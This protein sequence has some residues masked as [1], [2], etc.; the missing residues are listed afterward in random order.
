MLTSTRRSA[1]VSGLLIG[2]GAM[3]VCALLAATASAG[4][5]ITPG[6]VS[7]KAAPA[8]MVL[9]GR[10]KTNVKTS[11]NGVKHVNVDLRS[12]RRRYDWRD[13]RDWHR[14]NRRRRTVRSPRK[15]APA[16]AKPTKPVALKERRKPAEP[17][18]AYRLGE[19]STTLVSGTA[20]PTVVLWRGTVKFTYILGTLNAKDKWQPDWP[21]RSRVSRLTEGILVKIVASAASG[22]PA[23][24]D[25]KPFHP[26]DDPAK[27]SAAKKKLADAKKP[28]ANAKK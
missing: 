14:W 8:K 26:Q 25:L 5:I 4:S 15:P 11:S 27:K 19:L 7:V 10:A 24:L 1:M 9:P 17:P 20:L 12:P 18:G 23:L 3:V 28:P 2:G 22:R 13:R 21:L 16:P 6:K